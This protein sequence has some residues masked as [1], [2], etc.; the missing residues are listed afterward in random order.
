M[1]NYYKVLTSSIA[2]VIV[3]I[4]F[5]EL[6][7]LAVTLPFAKGEHPRIFITAADI[8]IIAAKV[9]E[10]TDPLYQHYVVLKGYVDGAI[11]SGGFY[12]PKTAVP[13]ALV[14]LIEDYHS[15]GSATKYLNAIKQ[16][17]A[18]DINLLGGGHGDNMYPVMYDW[19]YNALTP[20]ERI[21]Y[22]NILVSSTYIQNPPANDIW[23]K[24]LDGSGMWTW[25]AIAIWNETDLVGN[26]TN[27]LA[28]TRLDDVKGMLVNYKIP[29]SNLP[30]GGIN[31]NP[32]YYNKILRMFALE[33]YAWDKASGE[34]IWSTSIYLLENFFTRL[35]S[36]RMASNMWPVIWGGQAEEYHSTLNSWL[37][38]IGI[39]SKKDSTGIVQYYANEMIARGVIPESEQRTMWRL[40]TFYDPNKPATNYNAL[41]L[42]RYERGQV[43]GSD[44][45]WV[46]FRTGW[47][48]DDTLIGLIS[49]DYLGRTDS[50]AN[51]NAFVIYRNGDLAIANMAASDGGWFPQYDEF[52]AN[53]SG[54]TAAV[55]SI[56]VSD[57]NYLDQGQELW[58]PLAVENDFLNNPNP[59]YY[60]YVGG[61]SWTVYSDHYPV[62][63]P[64]IERGNIVKFETKGSY[65]Y[66]IGD[67]TNAYHPERL[68]NFQR[69]MAFLDKKYLIILDR[70]TATQPHFVKRWYLHTIREPQIPGTPLTDTSLTDGSTTWSQTDFNN[71]YVNSDIK[72]TLGGGR[73]FVKS[74]LP[75]GATLRKRG[76]AGFSYWRNDRNWDNPIVRERP[77]FLNS[78]F[79]TRPGWRLEQDIAGNTDDI[80]LNVL[81]PTDATVS[82]MPETIR[83]SQTDGNMPTANMV[84]AHIKDGTENKVV[85]F[86]SDPQGAV[87]TGPI[88]YTV[89]LTANGKNF[90]FDLDPNLLSLALQYDITSVSAGT[91]QTITISPGSGN[92]S[93]GIVVL[94]HTNKGTLVFTTAYIPPP[95]GPGSITGKITDLTTGLAISGANI[96]ATPGP[97]TDITNI[98]GDYT[99]SS[100]PSGNYTLN[101]IASGYDSAIIN[102]ITVSS[103]A[104]VNIALTP[105]ITTTTLPT[106][107]TSTTTIPTTTTTA[108][109]SSTTTTT[110]TG[111]STTTTTLQ[112]QSC[113]PTLL[114]SYNALGFAFAW[115]VYVSGNRAYIADGSGGLQIID[116]SNPTAPVLHGTYDTPGNARGVHVS[117]STAYVADADN[118]LQIINVSFP[119]APA[120]LGTYNTA[121]DAR[122]VYVSGSTAYVADDMDGLQ[123]IDVSNPSA[124]VLLGSY[125]TSGFA[126]GVYVS[127]STAYVADGGKG[128]QI[129]DVSNP[130][131][132]ALLGSYDTSGDAWSVYVSGSTAYVADKF[133]GLQI[134]DVSNPATPALLGSYDT[135]GLS[136]YVS[137]SGSTAYLADAHNGLQIVDVSNPAAPTLLGSYPT[138]GDAWGVYVFGST[139]YVADGN[140]GLQIL[141]ISDCV[142]SSDTTTTT[143]TTIATATTTTTTTATT[144]TTLRKLKGDSDGDGMPNGWEKKNGL[145]PKD[146]TDA[147]SDY[148]NDGLTALKEYEYGTDPN[149]PDTD[150]DG[151]FDGE[152]VR[153]GTDSS[154]PTDPTP[155]MQLVVAQASDGG[156]VKAL[157]YDGR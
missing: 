4:V 71:Q 124:P 18:N 27:S 46:Q 103:V 33:I 104:T 6:N 105:I 22:G 154:N 20:A 25:A 138:P 38:P 65:D 95:T 70:V 150:G 31:P 151:V 76:G 59:F 1:K 41:P 91:T 35:F 142:V 60:N 101:A 132:P 85:L 146:P 88:T 141:N 47:T 69:A 3:S 17:L 32:V 96:M 37:Y 81:Y 113:T 28:Q 123:I 131:I 107:T 2:L 128:L 66:T 77:Y 16:S 45:G 36:M 9:D 49:G 58:T 147:A 83:I 135:P 90:L 120:L 99:I 75:Q 134:I 82:S 21:T 78:A 87:P 93:P 102:N 114:S 153:V 122:D 111:S 62:Q 52:A 143:T 61:L 56:T 116:I 129:I 51:S 92:L 74:L 110:T 48:E 100:I 157:N 79:E 136:Y 108:T 94:E 15:P 57:P 73:M 13:A 14:Y 109:G 117:G 5:L 39:M 98:N 130:A 148:D 119:S 125:D 11:D 30:G 126:W 89:T 53:Y 86:S 24:V 84:G 140:G 118:G 7:A 8:P 50:Y 112:S 67:A 34:D 68:T 19:V 40:I 152:E 54:T 133:F 97:Y 80:F 64:Y 12:A 42:A 145:D 43:E 63:A 127:G 155:G 139:A 144:T 55:N 156:M 149:N 10:P 121:G 72:G 106:T 23:F 26:S 44:E 29:F 137:V 115:D